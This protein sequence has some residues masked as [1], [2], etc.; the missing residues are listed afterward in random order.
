MFL[1]KSTKERILNILTTGS[2]DPY[3]YVDA[4]NLLLNE[5]GYHDKLIHDGDYNDIKWGYEV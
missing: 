1:T 4:I 2:Y 5:L 3:E